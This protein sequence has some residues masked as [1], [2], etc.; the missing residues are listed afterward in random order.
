MAEVSAKAPARELYDVIVI[1]GGSAGLTAAIYLARACYRVL[2]IEKE[3]F[4]GQITIT[5]RVV[6]YPG[7][8]SISGAALTENMRQQAEAFGAEFKLAEVTALDMSGE[9]KTVHTTQG[10]LS[11]FGVLLAAGARP[12]SAGFAGEETFRGRGVAYCATC[13]GEFFRGKQVFVI[14]GGYAAAEESVFLTK[15]ASHVTCLVRGDDFSCAKATADEARNHPDITV[16]T[17]TVVESVEG[18]GLLRRLTCRDTETGEVKTYDAGKDTFGVF[19][20]AGYEPATELVRGIA[21]LDPKGYVITDASMKTSC[22]GLYAAGDIRIK[23]LR[24]CITAAGDGALAATELERYALQMQKKTGIRPLR[25]AAAVPEE[26]AAEAASSQIFQPEIVKQLQTV[27]ARMDRSLELRLYLED[28]SK[29]GELAS[30]VD[31]LAHL[32]HKL[33]VVRVP[34]EEAAAEG[35]RPCVRVFCGGEPAGIAFH[36]VPGGHEFTSFVLGLYNAAGPGQALDE[37]LRQRLLDWD[38]PCHLRI[39]VSLSCTLCPELVTAAQRLA[40]LNPR[41]TTDVYDLNLY[42]ALR[43]AYQVM[44]VPCFLINED[45][46]HFGKK[47]AAQLLDLMEASRD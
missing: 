39:F 25:P 33:Q 15:Y 26:P 3:H 32:T 42:P 44:S 24:Q 23:P 27:F 30:Y 11:C 21:D 6:N 29:S 36:G 40:T 14:G 31:E 38:T 47:T 1:G 46:P 35:E 17:H 37:S 41:I 22:D 8:A 19:V 45:G 10:L 13:D 18:D 43:E 34:A 2:V 20:F 9:I 7:I 12:R 28:S 4:G 5:D 16:R